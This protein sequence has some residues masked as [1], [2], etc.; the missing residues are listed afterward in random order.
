MVDV[1]G[2]KLR[3]F[4]CHAVEIF[5]RNV[6]VCADLSQRVLGRRHDELLAARAELQDG[7]PVSDARFDRAGVGQEVAVRTRIVEES[8]GKVAE[9]ETTDHERPP[10][11]EA[12]LF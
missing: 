2:E 1:S 8:L 3:R 9:G 10:E 7:F 4:R 11:S 12:A 5:R 6:D